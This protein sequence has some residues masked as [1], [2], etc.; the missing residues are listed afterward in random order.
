MFH[1]TIIAV[2]AAVALGCLPVLTSASAAD[3]AGNGRSSQQAV[4]GHA[5]SGHA[6]AGRARSGYARGGHGAR[7]GGGNYGGGGPI[8]DTCD[9][10]HGNGCPGFGVP[11]VGGLINGVLGGY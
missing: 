2:T 9:G 6:T 8:Y 1:K 4:S 7:Y 3:H 11:Y 5:V 10:Y